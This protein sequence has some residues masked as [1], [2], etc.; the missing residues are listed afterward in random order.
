MQKAIYLL[1][2]NGALLIYNCRSSPTE[3]TARKK[4]LEGQATEPIIALP[5]AGGAA[6]AQ[7]HESGL[8]ARRNSQTRQLRAV[9]SVATCVV[10]LDTLR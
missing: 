3:E 10:F 7:G 9:F 4:H 8:I 2:Q 6:S 1:A 5:S